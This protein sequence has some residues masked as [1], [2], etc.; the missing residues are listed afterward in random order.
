MNWS[1]FD[2]EVPA[3]PH[4]LRISASGY[5]T[6]DTTITVETGGTVRLG[7]KTLRSEGGL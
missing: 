3:G 2:V 1:A 6:F 7:T 5:L 4:R